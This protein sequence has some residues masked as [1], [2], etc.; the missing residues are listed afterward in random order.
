MAYIAIANGSPCVVPSSDN[1]H[2]P[3]MK[4]CV[5]ALS[6]NDNMYHGRADLITIQ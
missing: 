3:S 1:R 4:R 2:W 6:V 5:I